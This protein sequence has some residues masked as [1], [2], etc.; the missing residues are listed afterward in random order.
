LLTSPTARAITLEDVLSMDVVVHF[1]DV[2]VG[3]AILIELPDPE[4]EIIIDGGDRRKGYNINEYVDAYVDDPIEIALVTHPDYDHWSGI[5]RLLNDYTITELWDPGYD[6]NCKFKGA[7][8]DNKRKKDTYLKFI[9]SLPR[10]GMNTVKRPVPVDPHTPLLILDDVKF[11]VLHADANPTKVKEC[12]YI[13]NN[14][15]IVLKLDYKNVSFLFTGDGNGKERDERPSVEPGH[16]EA[17]LLALEKNN[18]GI[19]RSH[20]LKVP[21]HGSETANT[22]A[23]IQAVQPRYAVIS[24]SVTKNYQLPKKRVV[25]RYQRSR[26]DRTGRIEKVLRTNYGETSYEK[27]KFGHDHIICGTNGEPDDL[28]CDYIWNFAE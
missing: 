15:S 27:R 10:E 19:L 23:F 24:S 6:R 22:T 7:N 2:G 26:F 12:S 8:A 25:Q 28:V 11:T 13:I 16:V 9:R 1:I 21:H 14:A 4:H 17:K 18:P 20:V 5:D 3:D